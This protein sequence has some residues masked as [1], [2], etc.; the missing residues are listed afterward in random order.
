MDREYRPLR[1]VPGRI[2][3]EPPPRD[4]VRLAAISQAPA[5]T[6]LRVPSATE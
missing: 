6:S 2:N 4:R 5:V 3:E 1:Q